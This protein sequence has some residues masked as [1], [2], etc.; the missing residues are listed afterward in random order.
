M[1]TKAAFNA[2]EWQKLQQAPVTAGMYITLASPSIGDSLK[3]PMAVA[4]RIAKAATE[5]TG[6]ELM[7]TLTGE[8]KDFATARASKPDLDMGQPDQV[9][10]QALDNVRDAARL[11]EQKGTAAEAAEYKQWLYDLAR[12]SAEAAKEGDFM[13]IGGEKVNDAEREALDKLAGTLGLTV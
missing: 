8:F 6:S 3:E 1:T 9:K 11:V 4:S 12:A 7:Q 5:S 13:G 10:Q 2:D